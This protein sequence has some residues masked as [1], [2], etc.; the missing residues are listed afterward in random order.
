MDLHPFQD[1]E[2]ESQNQDNGYPVSQGFNRKGSKK[3]AAD[4][5]QGMK[6]FRP[7]Y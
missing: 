6:F 3:A 5:G 4:D 1:S 7:P 2:K